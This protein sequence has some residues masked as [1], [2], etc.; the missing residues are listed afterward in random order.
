[1]VASLR[2]VGD[3]GA[4][5]GPISTSKSRPAILDAFL[6][7]WERGEAPRAEVFLERIDPKDTDTAV[8]L[9]YRE[10]CLLEGAGE[11]PDPS[12]YLARFPQYRDALERLFRLHCEC[13]ASLLG[14]WIDAASA[15]AALPGAGDSIGPFLLRRELGRGGFARVFLAEQANLEDR[16]VVVK[17]TT[18]PTREPWLLA[19]LQHAHIVEILSQAAVDD[20]AFQLICMPFLGGATLASVLG[21]GRLRPKPPVSGRDLLADLDAVAAPEYVGTHPAHPA[22]E[23]LASLTFEQALAWVIARLAEALDHAFDRGVAHGDVK[24]SNILFTAHAIPMLLDFNLARDASFSACSADMADPGGT[25]AYMAPE[26]L[27]ALARAHAEMTEVPEEVSRELRARGTETGQPTAFV[28]LM[29]HEPAPHQADIYALGMVLLEALHNRPPQGP[30]PGGY[31]ASCAGLAGFKAV[32]LAY[33]QARARSARAVIRAA[34]CDRVIPPGLRVILEHCLDPDPGKRYRRCSELADDLDRWRSN[35]PPAFAPEPLWTHAVPRWLRRQRRTVIAAGLSLVVA[36]VTLFVTLHIARLDTKRT[37]RRLGQ[38][39]LDRLWDEPGPYRVQHVRFDLGEPQFEPTTNPSFEPDHPRVIETA[40]RALKDYGLLEAA[41]WRQREDVQFLPAQEREDLELWL[42]EQAFRYCKALCDRPDPADWQRALAI[43]DRV[44]SSSPATAFVR[45]TDRLSQK[46]SRALRSAESMPRRT[47]KPG[48]SSSFLVRAPAVPAWLEEYL[49]GV[50]AECDVDA[51]RP[52][53]AVHHVAGAGA[54]PTSR[55]A[56]DGATGSSADRGRITTQQAAARRA[57]EHY[58]R[59]LSARPDSYWAHYR[60]AGACYTLG[61]AQSARAAA[62]MQS[63]ARQRLRNSSLHGLYAACLYDLK[64]YSEALSECNKALDGAPDSPEFVRTRAFIRASAGQ[65]NGLAE[66]IDR[67][68]LLSRRLPPGLWNVSGAADSAAAFAATDEERDSGLLSLHLPAFLGQADLLRR[69]ERPER[70]ADPD[71]LV[72]RLGLASRIHLAGA[73]D[74]AFQEFSK[75]VLLDPDHVAARMWRAQAA[76]ELKRFDDAIAD[77]E[78]IA[79]HPGLDVYLRKD[80]ARHIGMLRYA[81]GEFLASGRVDV[82]RA[83]ASRALEQASRFDQPRG[84]IHFFL[85][86]A[87]AIDGRSNPSR[88]K[89]AAYHLDQ[90]FEASRTYYLQRYKEERSFDPVRRELDALLRPGPASGVAPGRRV[91]QAD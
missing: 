17:V 39:K 21:A 52:S 62:H 85:A 13:S 12:D 64:L 6:S 74:V 87:C 20:G 53:E 65:L 45:L 68:E 44:A 47:A 24:P 1:M 23:I 31:D 90:S 22:R 56:H 15:H 4:P 38:D 27:V 18:R 73:F 58:E 88:I 14:G 86:Q 9:I 29:E 76:L 89:D 67:F 69:G 34:A 66:D 48:P 7:A 40:F 84:L 28:T 75:I 11:N 77:L 51:A 54:E 91:A 72:A 30:D 59:V 79:Q 19:R 70:D 82:A 35:R 41:D 32:A 10:L 37:L 46:L 33:A 78:A 2:S 43:I 16:L 8:E 36:W 42:M 61:G 71:D 26:R 57:L 5:R 81:A 50:A 3:P 55:A 60:A 25:L 83:L 80:P 49:S 63:C